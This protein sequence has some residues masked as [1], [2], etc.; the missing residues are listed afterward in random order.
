MGGRVNW[1]CESDAEATTGFHQGSEPTTAL[2]PEQEESMPSARAEF[3]GPFARVT[4]DHPV[5][6]RINF[7]MRVDLFDAFEQV[8]A[9]K[10]T[11][12]GC[13]P[14]TPSKSC[15]PRSSSLPLDTTKPGSSP[16]TAIVLQPK[17]EPINADLI[18]TLRPI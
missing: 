9:S 10:R 11:C 17:C 12:C 3:D 14:S 6:N 16:G 13:R 18:R 1:S 5:G 4:L 15:E 7:E 8:A 2:L